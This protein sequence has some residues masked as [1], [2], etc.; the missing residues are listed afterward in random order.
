V[1]GTKRSVALAIDDPAQ[2]GCV[3]IVQRPHDDEDLPGVWGLPAATLEPGESWHD[4]ALRVGR[5]KL[6]VRLA[7]AGMLRGGSSERAGYTL[8]MRLYAA[9]IAAGTPH[10]PQQVPGITQYQAWRWGAAEELRPAADSGSLCS[11]LYLAARG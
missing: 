11:Q 9:H 2:P 6:G 1:R 8:E 7:I 10:V 4:A 3:L 5:D